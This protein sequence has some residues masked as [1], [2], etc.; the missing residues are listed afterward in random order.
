MPLHNPGHDP[1]LTGCIG[2][3]GQ[4]GTLLR[5]RPRSS[6]RPGRPASA[7]DDDDVCFRLA[8]AVGAEAQTERPGHL[9]DRHPGDQPGGDVRACGLGATKHLE[10]PQSIHLI[11]AVVDDDVDS[12]GA[13]LTQSTEAAPAAE[14]SLKA[15][16][17]SECA[18]GPQRGTIARMQRVPGALTLSED[19]R[20]VLAVWAAECAEQSLPLFEAQAA[21]DPR[22]REALDGV[23]AFASGELR[24]GPVRALAAA[25]HAAARDVTDPAAVAAARAAGHAAAVAHMASHALSAPAYAARAAALAAEDDSA[26]A[27]VVE[28]ADAH[29]SPAVRDVLRRL[30]S[31]THAPGPLGALLLELQ[32]RI[33][34]DKGDDQ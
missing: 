23:R 6:R 34:D 24:I 29:A 2:Q 16:P 11:E 10:R 32:R 14:L 17:T 1:R 15:I 19:D 26:G 13:S 9:L 30:P 7:G 12:H 3:Q 8:G 20:R 4:P 21:A 28:W 33:V 5:L 18:P 25:A 31:R 22:P 27:Q